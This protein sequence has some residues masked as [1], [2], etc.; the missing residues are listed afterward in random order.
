MQNTHGL[1][2]LGIHGHART[3]KIGADLCHTNANS[4][5]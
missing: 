5:G 2:R 3:Q 4:V 1:M